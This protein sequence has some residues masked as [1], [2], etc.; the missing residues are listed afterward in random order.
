MAPSKTHPARLVVLLGGLTLAP[1][2]PA[3]P[4]ASARTVAGLE[5]EVRGS[6]TR[7]PLR[8]WVDRVTPLAGRPVVLDRRID[9]DFPVTFSA[10]GEPLRTVLDRVAASADAAVDELEATLRIVPRSEAG[11]VAAGDFL[12]QR[13]LQAL[14]PAVRR[15]LAAAAPWQW[16][17]GA[18]PRDLVA[19]LAAAA[20][21]NVAG[22]DTIPHDHFP[23]AD[24][25][26]ISLAER[27]DLVLA[28]FDQRVAWDGQAG[29]IVPL[30]AAGPLPKR[31]SAKPPAPRGGER[32]RRA[33]KVR[34]T[35]TLRLEA[36][37]D[38]ALSAV[39]SQLDLRLDLDTASLAAS[40]IASGEIV[41]ADL[42]D[43]SRDELIAAIVRP[44]GLS[45]RIED[46]RLSVFAPGRDTE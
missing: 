24:L 17:A 14:P 23:A 27:F 42:T 38:Q 7:L 39:A 37:L 9:P 19:G 41:R 26:A 32:P 25:P 28:H 8:A 3:A 43:A 1:A 13:E 36:P 40:G 44:L 16:A 11:R 33:V 20:G 15:T 35:Y 18:R 2:L 31:P 6:W 21:L 12:R 29:R 10:R 46:G 4:P 34:Q 45:W 30:A 22:L 5:A